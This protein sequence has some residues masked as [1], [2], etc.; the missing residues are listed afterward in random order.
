[1]SNHTE[2]RTGTYRSK[3][4][5]FTPESSNQ[6]VVRKESDAEFE[7]L[8]KEIEWLVHLSAEQSRHFPLVL[9]HELNQEPIFY[10]MPH[11]P[12]P[13]LR[14]L[15][16]EQK[17][18]STDC[19][20]VL[21]NV[22]Q[23]LIEHIYS[24]NHRRGTENFIQ[25]AHFDRVEE[26]LRVIAKR[27]GLWHR[28]IH[29]DE[30][31]VNGSRM[32][33]VLLLLNRLKGDDSL[34]GKLT[35]DR[36]HMIHGDFHFDNLLVDANRESGEFILLDPRG[37]FHGYDIAYDLGK[38]W[39]SFHGLYDFIHEGLFELEYSIDRRG[40]F[41]EFHIREHPATKTFSDCNGEMTR[42]I[43]DIP[44]IAQNTNWFLQTVFAEASHFCALAPFHFEKKD[45]CRKT[46]AR[47]LMGLVLLN[48][49]YELFES[50]GLNPEN[51]QSVLADLNIVS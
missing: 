26:R 22:L 25:R 15:M 38:L 37:E 30:L 1:M 48:K 13:S 7:D 8:R 2:L 4:F 33:N 50:G 42:M 31:I 24:E 20:S 29:S 11:Y 39:H 32:V 43:V 47:Y 17:F 45:S 23:F 16:L 51:W 36:T 14:T 3:V 49:F 40:V 18:S 5:M 41:I 6:P 27:S 9:D 21:D 28:I 35:P 19:V 12:Y 46:L 34:C 10:T 44:F